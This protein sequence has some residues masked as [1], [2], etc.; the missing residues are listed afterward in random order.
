MNDIIEHHGVKGQRWGV[1]RYKQLRKD[2]VKI[3]RDHDEELSKFNKGIG[4]MVNQ[5]KRVSSAKKTLADY[6]KSGSVSK[7]KIARAEKKVS[8]GTS[9]LESLSG[10]EQPHADRLLALTKKYNNNV[11][12]ARKLKVTLVPSPKMDAAKHV[13]TAISGG[14]ISNYIPFAK[15]VALRAV[16]TS[17]IKTEFDKHVTG[18]K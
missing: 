15:N 5:A 8:K 6:K 14:I 17:A 12:E 10:K 2:S 9:K 16:S 18:E 4:K 1:K 13:I 7:G 11:A 3:A